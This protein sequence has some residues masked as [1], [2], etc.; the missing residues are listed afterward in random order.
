MVGG[1]DDPL[2]PFGAQPRDQRRIGFGDMVEQQ[3][4]AGSRV[5]RRCRLDVV[6]EADRDAIEQSERPAGLAPRIG[7]AGLVERGRVQLQ[8]GS[9][10]FIVA[11]DA[12]Q[13]VQRERFRGKATRGHGFLDLRDR[14]MPQQCVD[15]RGRLWRETPE[16]GFERLEVEGPQ[17]GDVRRCSCM[18]GCG[19]APDAEQQRQCISE[20]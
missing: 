5:H 14:R 7:S 18:H 9:Q 10:P 2:K 1:P 13:E 12:I 4:A 16:C 6:L 11:A 19:D 15:L 20:V 3:R 8:V 17:A